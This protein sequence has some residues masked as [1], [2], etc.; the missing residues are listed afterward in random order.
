MRV[1]SETREKVAGEMVRQYLKAYR[2]VQDQIMK[3]E[4]KLPE[5]YKEL[6]TGVLQRFFEDIA[7]ETCDGLDFN[8]KLLSGLIMRAPQR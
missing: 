3:A 8:V 5:P 4:G 1:N 7:S 6:E 2:M